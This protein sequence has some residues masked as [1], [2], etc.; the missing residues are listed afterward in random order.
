MNKSLKVI[1]SWILILLL[2]VISFPWMNASASTVTKSKI[3]NVSALSNETIKSSKEFG[4]FMVTATDEKTVIIEDNKKTADDGESFTKRMKLGGSGKADYRSIHFSVA[5]KATVTIYAMS[6]SSSEDRVLTLYEINGTEVGSVLTYGKELKVGIIEINEAGSY[7]LASPN[8]GVNIYA[9][10]VS[11]EGTVTEPERAEWDSVQEP[12]IKDVTQDGS[13]IIVTFELLTGINGADK[14]TVVMMDQTGKELDSVLIGKDSS[15]TNRIAEFVPDRSGIYKF[16]VIAERNDELTTKESNVSNEFIF[17]LPLSRPEIK[18]VTNKGKGSVEII[19]NPVK[20][21]ENYEVLYRKE[22]DSNWTVAT[23]VTETSAIV[24]SLTIG[25]N[26]AF[27]VKAIRGT[28]ESEPADTKE[29]KVIKEAQRPWYFAAFGQGVNTKNNY[30]SGSINEGSITI[31]SENGKG[32]LVPASTDGLAFYYTTIDPE[33]E[34]FTLS[35]TIS[36]DSWTYSNGQEGFGLMAADAVGVHGDNSV[37][38]NNSYMATVTKVE[39]FWDNEKNTVSDTGDKITMKLG[40]GAQEKIGVT[41]ENIADGTINTNI[42]ELFRSTMVPLDTSCAHYGAGT[43]NIVGNY[44]N[45]EAPTGTVK[46]LTTFK[47]AIQRDNT[48]YRLSYIDENGNKTTKLYYDIERDAL[49]QIDKDNIYVGF[50]ASRNAKITVT[51][52]ELKITNPADDPPPEEREITYITPSYR[53]ISP[54]ETGIKDHELIF[55]ANADGILSIKDSEENI[56]LEGESVKANTYVKAYVALRK[57][58]NNYTVEFTPDPNYK[59]SEYERLSSYD[60]V[61]FQHNVIYKTYN[62]KVLYVSP[63]GNSQGTGSKDN[64]L[65]IYTA[66][67]YVKPGQII[68]LEGGTYNL[69][70][71]VKVERGINGTEDN[72][73]YLIADPNATERPVFDFGKKCAGMIF[74]GDYWYIK[75]FD[76]TNSADGQKGIQLSGD[77]CVLDSVNAYY[78]GNTGI[79]IS[80]YLSTDQY[81]DW[82]SYNLVLNCTSY[83]NADKGYEDAD[84][85]A[86]K[87]TVGDGNIFDGCIAYNNADDGWDLFAKVETGP[88]GKV[89]I[90]NCIAYGNGYLPDGTNAGNGNGFKL[91]GSSI[92]GYHELINCIAYD[93]KAKGI[94]S[95]SCP[96]VQ[97]YNC[98]S[99]NNGSYNVALYTNDAVNTDFLADGIISYRTTNKSVGENIK[100]KGTQDIT[101]I[102]RPT[103]YYWD[104]ASETSYNTENVIVS[105]D[106]FVSLDTSTELTRNNDGTIN[107]NGLLELTDKAPE[108]AGAR[109]GGMPSKEFVIDKDED[110]DD[111]YEDR[112][113]KSGQKEDEMIEGGE[114]KPLSIK[115]YIKKMYRNALSREADEEG[116]NFYVSKLESKEMT[117]A[118]VIGYIVL[119]S[120][121]FTNRQLEDEDFIDILYKIIFNREP[122]EEGKNYWLI[123]CKEGYSRRWILANMLQAPTNE[124]YHICE[125]LG[126]IPGKIRIDSSDLLK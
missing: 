57:G 82:P 62:Q 45:L 37:F 121:E 5:G 68:V 114:G 93:N 79:Q 126:I 53:M 97:I 70:S 34:N 83:G 55:I 25:A 92:T 71:T 39:Y 3:L 51:D 20:E 119:E 105:D 61:T 11:L 122:D 96:D 9:I 54:T 109:I 36:V 98:T 2:V 56:V 85:F 23:T 125:R 78:N 108:D 90:R 120:P 41:A 10:I 26:Y 115:G 112:D 103:N 87:L 18:S 16:K 118:Q 38:W 35:A 50:F 84:G 12:V 58:I 106:W 63:N 27:S 94:D 52:I 21:A 1:M 7:Y 30:Y 47:L 33:T 48:G 77:H 107:V 100:P 19:W 81:E 75:G 44:K 72:M 124:Y 89:I 40:V 110:K 101:K 42:N 17:I 59:P 74:A 29:V 86:A 22:G 66:V 117:G 64:P 113:K 67:K 31:V 65:D 49:T 88:I 91:G 111:E 123:K 116:L 8:G 46:E 6:S 76:V 14:A 99:F 104:A 32:K 43:Y 102:Y 60:T 73:I 69:T 13:K 28:D 80:R 24:E 4:E 95:N 15:T